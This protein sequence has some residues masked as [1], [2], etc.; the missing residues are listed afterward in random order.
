MERLYE[1]CKWEKRVTTN[2][3]QVLQTKRCGS[4]RYFSFNGIVMGVLIAF[5]QAP[6]GR[7]QYATVI[8]IKAHCE[9]HFDYVHMCA[10]V[11]VMATYSCQR[12]G[13]LILFFLATHETSLTSFIIR[14]NFRSS[15]GLSFDISRPILEDQV[16]AVGGW[17]AGGNPSLC[18]TN[19]D[20]VN[21]W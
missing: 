19:Y 17:N 16:V 8:Y 18:A 12:W 15:V 3:G 7:R 13:S 1:A 4:G 14:S 5:F 20:F 10:F 9:A 2:C 21:S 6:P 11:C